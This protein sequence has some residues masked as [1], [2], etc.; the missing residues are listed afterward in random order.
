[1]RLLRF[2]LMAAGNQTRNGGVGG[3]MVVAQQAWQYLT[4]QDVRSHRHFGEDPSPHN[5]GRFRHHTLRHHRKSPLSLRRRLALRYMSK[6]PQS[7]LLVIL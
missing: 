5:G 6:R 3:S 7:N 4:Y 2:L 1:M